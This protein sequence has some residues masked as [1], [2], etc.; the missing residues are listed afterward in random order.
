MQRIGGEQHAVHA[1]RLDQD[2]DG[3]DLVSRRRDLVV[4]EDQRR[5]GGKSAEH[6]GS[7]TVIQMIEAMAQGLA[8][9]RDHLPL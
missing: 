5:V 3:G 6:V 1:E 9:K 8:I 4:S 7:G 2:L